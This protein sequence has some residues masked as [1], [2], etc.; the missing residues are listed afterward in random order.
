MEQFKTSYG[1]KFS[2]IEHTGTPELSNCEETVYNNFFSA[3]DVNDIRWCVPCYRKWKDLGISVQFCPRFYTIGS[4]TLMG[5]HL[6]RFHSELYKKVK[7][8]LSSKRKKKISLLNQLK[9]PKDPTAILKH[10]N[11]I[12]MYLRLTKLIKV[13]MLVFK[14]C[15]MMR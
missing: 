9:L 6:E 3:R 14:L 4:T 10:H 13:A 8:E 11:I 15:L 7:D 12:L 2:E 5:R 1:G